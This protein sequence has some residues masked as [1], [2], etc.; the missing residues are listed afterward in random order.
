[1]A[2]S[3]KM[4]SS[5]PVTAVTGRDFVP[6]RLAKKCGAWLISPRSLL[7]PFLF[8]LSV[9]SLPGHP[10]PHSPLP[11]TWPLRSLPG[12]EARGNRVGDRRPALVGRV[13]RRGGAQGRQAAAEACQRRGPRPQRRIPVVD[14]YVPR[15]LRHAK[16][17]V[18]EGQ[19]LVV[20]IPLIRL[21]YARVFSGGR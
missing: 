21:N 9:A 11:S 2:R 8:F 18:G 5:D 13:S 1:M 16:A 20:P 4:L 3:I 17:R 14:S 12:P 15:W 10:H 7:P 6:P 19:P